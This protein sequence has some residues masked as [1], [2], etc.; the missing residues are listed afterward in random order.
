MGEYHSRLD[1]VFEVTSNPL[2]DQ[3]AIEGSVSDISEKMDRIDAA[4]PAQKWL[5]K[6]QA[7]LLRILDRFGRNAESTADR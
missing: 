6:R 5:D 7:V 3:A 4:D 2:K 1:G